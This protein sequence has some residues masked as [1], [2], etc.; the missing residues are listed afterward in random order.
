MWY[1]PPV[2][3][4][5]APLSESWI[6]QTGKECP[7][8][9]ISELNRSLNMVYS[10]GLQ[11]A[12]TVPVNLVSLCL[13]S[14]DYHNDAEGPGNSTKNCLESEASHGSLPNTAIQE[15]MDQWLCS[16]CCDSSLPHEKINAKLLRDWD[17]I[18]DSRGHK[19]TRLFGWSNGEFTR[20]RPLTGESG[21]EPPAPNESENTILEQQ[22]TFC[23]SSSNLIQCLSMP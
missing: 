7:C 5:S 9:S 23:N 8:N 19:Y 11:T 21:S 1:F 14:A 10:I 2:T 15:L 18:K 22:T 12:S 6:A 20:W 17:H 3:S 13:S 16:N 4:S